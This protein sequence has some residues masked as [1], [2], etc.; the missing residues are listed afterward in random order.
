MSEATNFNDFVAKLEA[1]MT[2]EEREL[3]D[4]YRAHYEQETRRLRGEDPPEPG[5]PVSD[6]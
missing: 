1:R 6:E 2:D 5:V 4:A 3:L